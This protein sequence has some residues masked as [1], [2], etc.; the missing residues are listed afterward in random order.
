MWAAISAEDSP[1]GLLCTDAQSYAVRSELAHI[2]RLS[3][4]A[5]HVTR[6]GENWKEIE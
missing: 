2:A 5:V 6:T 1:S 3:E 4:F